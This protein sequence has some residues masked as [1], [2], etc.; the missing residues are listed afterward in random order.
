MMT[1]SCSK[2]Q[3]TAE[4]EITKLKERV[5]T[6]T[7]GYEDG[8]TIPLNAYYAQYEEILNECLSAIVS[9]DEH[10]TL[11]LDVNYVEE[12]WKPTNEYVQIV[13]DG[14]ITLV[15]KMLVQEEE[16][17][18]IPT[19][20]DGFRVLTPKTVIFP[21]SDDNKGLIWLTGTDTIYYG[22][23]ENTKWSYLRLEKLVDELLTLSPIEFT[24]IT[25]P[26]T[27]NGEEPSTDIPWGSVVYHWANGITEVYGADNNRI[28]IAK[29][30]EAAMLPHPSAPG[31]P[32]ESPATFIYQVPSGAH[33]TK[34]ESDNITEIYLDEVLILT[35]IE[36]SEDFTVPPRESNFNLIFKYGIFAKNELNTFNGTY[37]KDMVSDPSITVELSL[38]EEELDSI[39][40][41]MIEIDFFNYPDKFSIV[42]SPND[43]V[44]M[45][46]PYSSY[47]F[48]VQYDSRIKELRWEDEILNP[49]IQA[50]KLMELINLIRDIIESKDEYKELPEPTSGYL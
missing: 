33:I 9:I 10:V 12:K 3:D 5:E 21:L 40:E 1:L 43:L 24:K 27:L 41:K 26:L 4:S 44:R 45:V 18:H 17:Y 48:K 22:V 47:Y 39:Y 49:D 15:T 25:A 37:T 20:A 7:V 14:L 31:Q 35:V 2:Q 42:P 13:F 23:W 19:N 36:K 46:T 8:S 11:V 34:G 28:F 16:R 32:S 30:S 6:V 29:D 38:T 50:D